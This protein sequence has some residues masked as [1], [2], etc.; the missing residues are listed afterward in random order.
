MA[1]VPDRPAVREN[2]LTPADDELP[3]GWEPP[4]IDPD[5]YRRVLGHLPTGVTVVTAVTPD[6]PVGL[7]IGSFTSVSLDPA[8]VGFLPARASQS[9]PRIREV[10]RFCVN[11]LAGGQ[12]DVARLFAAPHDERFE[13]VRW[14]PAPFSGAPLLDGVTAWVDCGLETVVPAGDHDFVLGRVHELGVA[15]PDEDPLVF[16]RGGYRTLAD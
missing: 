3:D 10:G 5:A 6:G 2:A 12:E 14:R 13:A 9:W 8:L 16:F 11:V 4:A 7:S 15:A 1:T